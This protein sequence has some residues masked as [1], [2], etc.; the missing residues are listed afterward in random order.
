MKVSMIC[1]ILGCVTNIILDPIL[2][3]GLGIF[4]KLGIKG[5]AIATVIGQVA[6]LLGYILFYIFRPIPVKVSVKDLKFNK[7]LVKKLYSIGFP[8]TLNMA[9][10]SLQVSVLNSILSVYSEG[11]VLVLGAYYKYRRFYI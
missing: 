4:P 5:A 8:A 7:N 6:T 9:L 11:Y 10:P 1:M 2:I 3:F